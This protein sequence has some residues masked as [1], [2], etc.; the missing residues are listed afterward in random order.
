MK[1]L[2]T[3]LLLLSFVSFS[4]ADA[5][6]CGNRLAKTGDAKAYVIEVCGQPISEDLVSWENDIAV[7]HL[8][9][10]ENG[11]LKVLIFKGGILTSIIDA[12]K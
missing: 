12:K 4:Y 9:Y 6:R 11:N 2:F 10:K 7:Y 5:I 8:T 3:T 1:K